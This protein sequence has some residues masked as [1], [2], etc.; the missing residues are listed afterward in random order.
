MA[1][2]VAGAEI[3]VQFGAEGSG[4]VGVLDEDGV[5]TVA[6][7][8]GQGGGRDVLGYPVGVAGAAVE[9][10]DGGEVGAEVGD[11]AGET[12]LEEAGG[13]DGGEGF[14]GGS[15]GRAAGRWGVG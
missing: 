10:G 4:D 8:E 13:V 2:V 12:V 1:P 9:G 7:A 15:G 11:G 6:V 3:V 14:F 5:P